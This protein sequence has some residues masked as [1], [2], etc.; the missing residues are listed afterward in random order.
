[1]FVGVTG[2]WPVVSVVPATTVGIAQWEVDV[3]QRRITF[4]NINS[5]ISTLKSL[6][7]LVQNLTNMV[8]NDNIADLLNT[9]LVSLD[10]V[11]IIL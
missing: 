9:V 11:D 6:S 4:Y 2:N 3:I 10:K 1:M 5:T 7:R 8:V